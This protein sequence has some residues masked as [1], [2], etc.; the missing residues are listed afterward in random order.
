WAQM[1]QEM[2]SN[3]EFA[4]LLVGPDG[5]PLPTDFPRP[6]GIYQGVVCAATGGRPTDQYANRSELLIRGGS[7]AQ[8]CD[9]LSA[10]ARADLATTLQNMK[11]R[12]GAFVG[13]AADSIYAYARAVRY[14]DWGTNPVFPAP[15]PTEDSA[16]ANSS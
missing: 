9:Q 8:R 12:G 6:P 1:M 7:P 13:G 3:P 15:D 16:P 11:E 4:K 10:W 2:H 14:N 5:Q